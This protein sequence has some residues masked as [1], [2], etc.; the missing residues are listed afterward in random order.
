MEDANRKSKDIIPV[1]NIKIEWFSGT[2]KG[3][4]HRNKHQNSCRL[5][6]LI[7]G[8]VATAQCRSRKQSYQQAY[9]D[10]SERVS[11]LN[12]V[13]MHEKSAKIRKHQVGTGMRADKKR[14]YRFQ[15]GLII[16]HQ[17]DKKIGEKDFSSG[18]IY[19]LW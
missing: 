12:D 9:N 3:G 18:K 15:D 5:T 16:D 10:L 2:G 11:L 1:E 19:K 13:Q 17:T 6:H 7:T 14:T 8:T 4:Q